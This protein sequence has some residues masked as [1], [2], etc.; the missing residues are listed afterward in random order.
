MAQNY[1]EIKV[2]ASDTAKPDLTALKFSL[3][4]L[5]AK[6]ETARVDV[7]DKDAAA[8]LLALN[9]RLAALDKKVSNPRLNAAGAAKVEADIAAID[10]ALDHLNDKHAKPEVTLKGAA[11]V[12]AEVAALDHE[13]DKLDRK[14][15]EAGPG[16]LLGKI[17]GGLGKLQIPDFVPLVGGQGGPAGLAAIVPVAGALL[18]EVTG[19]VSGFA[20][21]GAGAGAFA[22][23]AMPAV[24]HVET[25]YTALSAAQQKYQAA[26]A[27]EA[28]DPTKGNAKAL[29]AAAL[30]LKLAHEA[31]GKMPASEQAAIDGIHRLAS[32]FGIMSK[33]FEPEAFKVFNAG[34]QLA[35]R[36]LPDIVPFARTFADVLSQLLG[37]A[38]QF[39]GS[40]G[41]ADWLKQFHS[42]EGPALNAI[43][44]GIGNVAVAI[45]KLLTT[46]SGKD[47]A[48]SINIAFGAIA[49]TINSV[50]AT[51]K[52][53]MNLWDAVVVEFGITSHDIR[54]AFDSIRHTFASAGS[55]IA[56][57]FDTMRHAAATWFHD[58]AA[59][60]DSVR[61]TIA[62]WADSTEQA[63]GR[64][65]AWFR[66][67]PGR[68]TSALGS[69]GSLL[70]H[71]GEAV[72]DGL[73]A[74]IRS[75]LGPLSS[76]VSSIGH[77]IASLKGPIPADLLLL[78]P[79]GQ[80]I[81]QGLMNGI[82]S[83]LPDLRGQLAG[84]SGTISGTQFSQ[85]PGW[86]QL[87]GGG[88]GT[89]QLQVSAGGASDLDQLLLLMIRKF[90]RVKGGGDVQKAF[91]T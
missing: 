52:F 75:K 40:K 91:G 26:Q 54:F 85:V 79:H 78:V 11:E 90:V 89:I 41:F 21:A 42:I 32:E 53:F 20:A 29:Q 56:H 45:G 76:L 44:A 70:V 87:A 48:H 3:D 51:V 36:L 60:F 5:G 58:M 69:L 24:K 15:E 12:L 25:A 8:K 64:V 17:I 49:G 23:L 80:A 34:L 39:A 81:M 62:S 82:A 35:G 7:D 9:A 73:M 22:L 61:H 46:M 37:R 28:A 47:V 59:V 77:L 88:G 33:A 57:N 74:G 1:V 84:I 66:A 18:T 71:A 63:G 50:A 83:R 72:I 55:D 38:S 16:G 13:L 67:L 31:I 30:N 2:K 43:G 14:A 19:L 86:G 68:I 27:K 6:V 10:A 65:V 4:E